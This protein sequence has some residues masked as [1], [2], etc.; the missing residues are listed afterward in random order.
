MCR[1]INEAEDARQVCGVYTSMCVVYVL[2]E[3][4]LGLTTLHF[5]RFCPSLTSVR[6]LEP[7]RRCS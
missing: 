1:R 6:S 3:R 5:F 4:K 7:P 2:E